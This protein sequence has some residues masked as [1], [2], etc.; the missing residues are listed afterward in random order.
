M[1]GRRGFGLLRI[2]VAVAIVAVVGILAFN[3]G[4]ASGLAAAG[5][6][7]GTRVP[8]GYGPGFGFGF[9]FLGFLLTI[10]LVGLL[11]A[12]IARPRGW[13]GGPGFRGW[14]GPGPW[15][16][17]GHGGPR[18]VPPMFEPMLESWHRRAHGEAPRDAG[19]DEQRRSG[20]QV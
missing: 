1:D 3:A 11:V 18:D 6:D 7:G 10:L 13:H 8:V 14:Y 20:E 9:G 2:L 4:V 19:D 16:H 15:A 12:A 17:G 5:G